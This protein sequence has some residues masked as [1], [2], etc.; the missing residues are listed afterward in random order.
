MKKILVAISIFIAAS[1]AD[2][3]GREPQPKLY[4]NTYLQKVGQTKANQ[5]IASCKSAA[6]NYVSSSKER[7]EGLR[8]GVKGAAKG[9]LLG[10]AGGAIMGNTGRGAAA[11]AV[12]GGSASAIKGVSESGSRDPAFQQYVNSCLEDKGYKV[13]EWK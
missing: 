8:K 12:V 4:P 2:A 7:G 13:I 6:T 10:T 5:D 11:G 3:I 9:A 1:T